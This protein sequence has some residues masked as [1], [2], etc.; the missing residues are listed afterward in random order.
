M[1]GKLRSTS[2]FAI[3]SSTVCCSILYAQKRDPLLKGGTW[4]FDKIAELESNRDDQ[5]LLIPRKNDGTRFELSELQGDQRQ[6]GAYVLSRW[7]CWIHEIEKEDVDVS[8]L[9]PL[10]MTVVGA[11]GTGKSVLINTLVTVLR[12]MFETND[13]VFVGAPT[14]SAAFKTF[15][16]TMHRL[17]AVPVRCSS[18]AEMKPLSA[19]NT[20]LLTKRYYRTIA[21]VCDERSL[22]SLSSL[23]YAS[24]NF[25]QTAFGGV[26]NG[27]DAFCGIP[28]FILLEWSMKLCFCLGR[29][30]M[31]ELNLC[32]GMW[33]SSLVATV[34]L[35]GTQRTQRCVD[36]VC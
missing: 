7:Y 29:I 1:G 4:L 13:C 17:F 30:Q 12:E 14:G 24:H 9:K 26:Y 19:M 27:E 15:G 25:K 28:M 34:G 6:V 36:C 32:T 35:F 23:G 18:S 10:R 31:R 21:G 3:F 16:E 33:S 8:S 5:A 11:A 20:G 22:V 2:F